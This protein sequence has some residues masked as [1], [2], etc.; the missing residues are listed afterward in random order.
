MQ[1]W[2]YCLLVTARS[3]YMIWK[4]SASIIRSTKNCSN[5]GACHRSGWYISTND[6]QGRLPTALCAVAT[7]LGCPYWI[8]SIPTHDMHQ[9]LLECVWNLMAHGDAREGKWGGNWRTE[10]V[11]STLTFPRNVVYP[12][13]LPLMRKLRLPAV[14]WTD[15]PTDV[16]GL[17]RFGERRNLVSTHVP[18]HFKRTILQF[19]ILL[20][21]DAGRV[22]N[23]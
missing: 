14:D 9:W 4:F 13:L 2:Q 17:V 6:V 16:N 12:A 11:A 15:S 10:W 7:D 3:L 1:L 19:L 8:Y 22:R 23:I 20:M 21:M 18:S 5:S